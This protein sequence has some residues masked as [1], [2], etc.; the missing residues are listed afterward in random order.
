MGSGLGSLSA[1]EIVKALTEMYEAAATTGLKIETEAVPLSEEQYVMF[2]YIYWF[3]SVF[4]IC[5]SR[6]SRPWF[7]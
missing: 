5:K 4:A 6:S 2:M 7:S 1:A 3:G